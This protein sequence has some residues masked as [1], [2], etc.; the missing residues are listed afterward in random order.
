M[1]HRAG[2]DAGAATVAP[3]ISRELFFLRELSVPKAAFGALPNILDQDILRRTPFQLSEIWHAATA[4]GQESDGVVPMCHWIIRRDR[5]EAALSEL[6]LTSRDVD[7]LAVADA[8]DQKQQDRFPVVR[9]H[10][11]DDEGDCPLEPGGPVVPRVA[12]AR[13]SSVVHLRTR[14][15]SVRRRRCRPRS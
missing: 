9:L 15:A 5:A 13:L 6:G 14:A 10:A 11:K 4:M 3:V 8:E 7:C 2:R 12:S 1:A